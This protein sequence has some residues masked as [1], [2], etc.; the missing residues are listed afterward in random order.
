[1]DFL[2]AADDRT[3]AAETAAALVEGGAGAV[4]VVAW[5]STPAGGGIG[6]IDLGS[7]HLSPSVAAHRARSVEAAVSASQ[8]QGHKID[9]TLRGNWADEL[10][11]RAALRPVLLVPALPALGRICEQGIVLEHG[12]PVHEGSAGN[13]VRR[14]VGSSRPADTLR[15]AGADR[16]DE[17]ADLESVAAWLDGASGIAVVDAATD[18][19]VAAIVD[20]W[21]GADGVLLAGTSVVLG[22]AIRGLDEP[23]T[24]FPRVDGPV[25][26]VCGSV[27]PAARA[28]LLLAEQQGVIVT[29]LADDIAGRALASSDAMVLATEI[30]IGDVDEPLAIAAATSLARGVADLSAQTAL[31]ALV[32]LGGDTAA[33]VLG[34]RTMTVHG[35]IGPGTPWM[36]AAGFDCPVITRAGGFGSDH[37][38]MEL[39][40]SMR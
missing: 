10:V 12:R 18:E 31:G 40:R 36:T 24:P 7:R 23:T 30:P 9:S 34:D 13:D 6:V 8:R 29:Y 19:T 22:A 32:I 16:V 14:R 21:S 38:L 26:V 28:Q 25:L 17:L 15:S 27:H 39:L 5:P 11:A 20:A 4:P 33:A 1:M 35:T 2:V 37:A 3:G